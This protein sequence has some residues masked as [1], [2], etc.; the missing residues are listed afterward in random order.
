ME[1]M[2]PYAGLG[3]TA[4][5]GH[6]LA[7]FLAWNA[8]ALPANAQSPSTLNVIDDRGV[9]VAVPADAKRVA[10]VSYF[11]ADVALALGIKQSLPPTWSKAEIR[12]F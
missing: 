9:I 10:S 1:T 5:A 2:M 12:T 4:A 8:C 6:A 7:A 3:R 11:A